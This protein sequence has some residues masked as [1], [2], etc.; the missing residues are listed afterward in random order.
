[1]KAISDMVI[2]AVDLVEAEARSLRRGLLKAAAAMALAMAGAIVVFGA[3]VLLLW[4]LY[5]A[6]SPGVGQAGAA[7]I[8]AVI[9]IVLAGSLIGGA[10]WVSR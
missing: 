2:A 7:L 3:V 6:M 4:G 10:V 5:L 9:G 1:M 8:T